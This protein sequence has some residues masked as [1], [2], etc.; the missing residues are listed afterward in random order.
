MRKLPISEYS[1]DY[2]AILKHV[3]TKWKMPPGRIRPGCRH[4]PRAGASNHVT[5]ILLARLG[6]DD[7]RET[8][9]QA[10]WLIQPKAAESGWES[11][12]QSLAIYEI[13]HGE[14]EALIVF[15]PIFPADPFAR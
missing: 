15:Y 9:G 12:W 10:E 5:P 11:G 13:L 2:R 3:P 1:R 4:R 7:A 14:A 6:R 8:L